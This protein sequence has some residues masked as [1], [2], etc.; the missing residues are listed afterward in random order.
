MESLKKEEKIGFGLFF[1]I[2]E[3]PYD[4]P[5]RNKLNLQRLEG[6]GDRD[7]FFEDLVFGSNLLNF[8][9][10]GANPFIHLYCKKV[11]A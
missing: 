3:K 9:E 10:S 6:K 2:K 8:L 4:T 1:S 7:I 5:E 11:L